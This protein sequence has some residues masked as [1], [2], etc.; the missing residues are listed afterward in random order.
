MQRIR[1]ALGDDCVLEHHSDFIADTEEN[2]N[3]Y[4]ARN[5]RWD[6]A[7]V[8]CS[9]MV[10]LLDTL[11]AAPRRN[12]RRLASLAGSVLLLDEVQAL[13]LKHTYLFTHDYM[14]RR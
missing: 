9:T 12:V 8:I 13:P 7:P 14:Q 4:L 1:E 2:L 10:Q 3:I 6:G 11:F 5:S